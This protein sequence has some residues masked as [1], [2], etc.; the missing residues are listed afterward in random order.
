MICLR[1][2]WQIWTTVT[3]DT[4]DNLYKLKIYGDTKE[5]LEK[6]DSGK[7]IYTQKASM[8]P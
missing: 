1:K 7:N 4:L 3:G 2:K 8:N 6:K 5:S